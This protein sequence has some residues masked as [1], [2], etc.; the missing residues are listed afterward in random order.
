MDTWMWSLLWLGIGAALTAGLAH[1]VYATRLTAARTEAELLR[2][3]V[4]DLEAAVSESSE[5]ASMLAPMREALARV[6]SH[7]DVLERDRLEQFGSLHALVTSVEGRTAELSKATTSLAGSMRSSTTRGVWGEVQLRRVLEAAG[8]LRHCD[9][10]EQVSG[11]NRHSDAVRPDVVV[12]LPGDR[13]L[14][15]DA[16]APMTAFLDAQADTL[17]EAARTRL[18]RAHAV[19]VRG[20]VGSLAAKDYWSALGTSPEVT[21]CFLPGDAML[22]AALDADPGLHEWALDHH[23]AIVGPAALLALLRTV[24]LTW[25]QEALSRNAAELLAVGRELH[26]RLSTLGSHAQKMGR[27]LTASVE[28]Y[29]ALVGTLEHRVLV[30]ARTFADLGASS[31]ELPQ[32]APLTTAAR[33]LTAAE[34]VSPGDLSVVPAREPTPLPE[35][36]LG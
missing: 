34:L 18:L 31:D 20:H 28:A 14:V 33:S 35:R 3:R 22:A 36:R 7:V 11:I 26:S 21:V 15:I 30:S 32:L 2:E 17:D 23:V 9:F 24:A 27:S 16:K 4:V 13:Q 12:H 1:V 29:N 5:T 10:E 19:A 6:E 8:M 25:R